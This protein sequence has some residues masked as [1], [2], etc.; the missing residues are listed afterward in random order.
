M[1]AQKKRSVRSEKFTRIRLRRSL[2][3]AGMLSIAIINFLVFW[4]YVNFNSILMAF[5][6]Q[7]SKGLDWTMENF[8]RFF[9]EVQIADFQ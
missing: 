6:M 2:F 9:P 3:I 5:Q 1:E 4:L 7:T 8:E